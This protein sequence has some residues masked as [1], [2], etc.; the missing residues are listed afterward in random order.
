MGEI[1]D[2]MIDGELDYMTGEYLGPGVGYPRTSSS[3]RQ[4]THQYVQLTEGEKRVKKIRKELAILIKTKQK[5]CTTQ[6]QKN[7]CVTL[8]RQE[9]NK[10]Y[11]H[12]WRNPHKDV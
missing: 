5:E 11:G 9:I 7:H 4:K 10:K 1:A 2:A 6:G 8:A 12:D 3:G